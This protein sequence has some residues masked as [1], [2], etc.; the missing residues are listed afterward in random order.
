MKTSPPSKPGLLADDGEDEVGLGVRQIAVAGDAGPEPLAKHVPV[1]ESEKGLHGL[2]AGI[3]GV[4]ERM[5]KRR[6][7]PPPVGSRHGEQQRPPD[8]ARQQAGQRFERD[9]GRDQHRHPDAG[10]HHG[11]A[12]VG[13]GHDQHHQQA[14]DGDDRDH[15]VAPVPSARPGDR[16]CRPRRAPGP[17]WPARRAAAAR[18]TCPATSRRPEARTPMPGTSTANSR[19]IV[20][21]MATGASRRHRAV[22]DAQGHD[23]TRRCR[24]PTT[25]VAARRSATASRTAAG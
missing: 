15:L 16:G 13:L 9:P 17:A 12:H 14:E 19:P 3:A 22:I 2:V 8:P 18:T 21:Y 6:H 20:R 24:S 7:A 1:A 4:F 23:E 25:S 11:R 10:Q 5:K